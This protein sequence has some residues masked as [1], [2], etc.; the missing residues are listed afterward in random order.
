[1]VAR[2]KPVT[3]GALSPTRLSIRIDD[4]VYALAL[5]LAHSEH[6]SLGKAINELARRGLN[7]PTPKPSSR[8][9]RKT[10]FPV[11]AGKRLITTEDVYR[12]ESEDKA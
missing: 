5:A 10:D 2:W 1:M 6:I 3:S 4:D 11:S 7:R 12:I 9:R 8:K